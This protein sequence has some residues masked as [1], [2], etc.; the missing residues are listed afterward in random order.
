ML[1][2]SL[3]ACVPVFIATATS[4]WASAGASLVPSPVMATRCPP[5]CCSRISLS[6]ASGVACAR[7]S[8]TPA[9]AAMAAAVNGLSPVIMTVL[10]PICRSSSKRSRMPPLTISLSWITP[11]TWGL[12]PLH[13]ATTSGVPPVR[14]IS[15]TL[16]CTPAESARPDLRRKLHGIGGAF[17]NLAAVQVDAA[18]AG[19][20][21]E[22]DEMCAKIMDVAPAQVVGLLGQHDDAAPFRRFVGQRGKLG[23]VRQLLGRNALGRDKCRRLPVAQRDGAR[24]VQQQHVHVAGGF[25]RPPRD[26]DHVGLDHAVHAGDADRRQQAADRGRDE[27]D[28][29]RDQHR[30]GDGVPRPAASTA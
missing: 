13:S 3:A 4:A 8:S 19:L 2:A 7:K 1:P 11:S 20:R 23:G 27:A 21:R 17:A 18:H 24:L 14:A 22:R 29:Q 9:S 5:S 25:D 10:M 28:Q 30:D 16:P 12:L 6:L 26:G 15:S